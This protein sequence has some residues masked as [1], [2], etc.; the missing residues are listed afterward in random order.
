MSLNLCDMSTRKY[1]P[2]FKAKVVLESLRGDVSHAEICRR[3]MYCTPETGHLS[4]QE[5]RG[6][7]V[8]CVHK[9]VICQSEGALVLNSRPE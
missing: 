3:Y 9:G 1:S 6:I 2:E 5:M 8:R 4:K 7:F